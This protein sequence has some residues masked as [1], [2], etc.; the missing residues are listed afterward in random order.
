MYSECLIHC[1]REMGV[2]HLPK[3][4]YKISR[5]KRK[6]DLTFYYKMRMHSHLKHDVC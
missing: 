6:Q 5:F 2:M 4:K 1:Y 3:L